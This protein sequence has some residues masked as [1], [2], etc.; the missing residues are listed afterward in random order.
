MK[1]LLV[2][3][4][5]PLMYEFVS[6]PPYDT[7]V[8]GS[9]GL[10]ELLCFQNEAV[11]QALAEGKPVVF[12]TPGLPQV[13]GNRALRASLSARYRE[14][15]SWGAVFTDGENRRV[16]TAEMA[17]AMAQRGQQPPAGAVLTPSAKEILGRN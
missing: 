5:P 6:A 3:Q 2:G 8:V 7:V 17:R 16:I 15:K 12:Y 13:S 10:G 9:M 14:L 11:L 4:K 1:A